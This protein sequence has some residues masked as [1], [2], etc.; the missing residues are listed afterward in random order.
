[1]ISPSVP[2]TNRPNQSPG[3]ALVPTY[4]PIKIG[5]KLIKKR[6]QVNVAV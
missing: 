6:D 1:M 3:I 5:T 4:I 2:P